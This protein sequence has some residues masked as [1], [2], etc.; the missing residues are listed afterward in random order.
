MGVD[1]MSNDKFPIPSLDENE[2]DEFSEDR[3]TPESLSYD[4]EVL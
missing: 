1:V 4:S 2:L 3:K